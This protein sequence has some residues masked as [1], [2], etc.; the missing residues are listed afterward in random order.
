MSEAKDAGK[1]GDK[2]PKE[3]KAPKAEGEKPAETKPAETK[4]AE[5]KKDVKDA[6]PVQQAKK[7]V[8]AKP[9]DTK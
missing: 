5:V 1:K 6:K 9:T 7:A 8:V 4:P 2:K 3:P